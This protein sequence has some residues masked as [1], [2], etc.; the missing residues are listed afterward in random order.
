MVRGTATAAVAVFDSPSTAV[1][2]AQALRADLAGTT[3]VPRF[4][5]HVGE[6][7]LLAGLVEGIHVEVAE[8]VAQAAQAGEVLA[9]GT[10]A[11][12]LVGSGFGWHDR[13]SIDVPGIAGRWRLVS[14]HPDGATTASV[15]ADAE[16]PSFRRDGQV[17]TLSF[18]GV[19]ARLPDLK[20]L[21]DIRM[22][23]AHPGDPVP[24][25]L[26]AGEPAHSGADR[27]LD[28]SAVRRFRDRL[29]ALDAELARADVTGD[30]TKAAT[31]ASERDSLLAELKAATGS[32]AD[33]GASVIRR[34]APA[35]RSPPEFV[36]RSVASTP[37]T[38]TSACTCALPFAPVR[39][40]P[41]S[42]PDPWRGG[43]SEASAVAR[44][45]AALRG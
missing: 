22:L 18:A 37:R 2:C 1:A 43:S 7:S 34:N 11:D 28:T 6:V 19:T 20:G 15:R 23:L 31:A 35:R 39:A 41:T 29:A 13:Q 12:L 10:T 32:A 30:A 27:V 44:L 45:S 33:S 40:V 17:W 8:R 4:G 9:T 36:M 5:V 14:I 42:R 26:L 16:E 25:A 38:P 24:A 21:T 3:A